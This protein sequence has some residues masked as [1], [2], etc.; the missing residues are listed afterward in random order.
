[1]VFILRLLVLTLAVFAAVIAVLNKF[2]VLIPSFLPLSKRVVIDDRI[3]YRVRYNLSAI[4][5]T[6]SYFNAFQRHS[7]LSEGTDRRHS[8]P[9]ITGDGFRM[10]A[11]G[12]YDNIFQN[13]SEMR[14]LSRKYLPI[15]FIKT[16][17]LHQFKV[18][19]LE[20]FNLESKIII[21]SHNSDFGV[22]ENAIPLISDPRIFHLFAQ[23][24][25]ISIHPKISCIPI[26]YENRYNTNGGKVGVILNKMSS[27]FAKP[28][29]FALGSFSIG[30][31][32]SEREPLLNLI[33]SLSHVTKVNGLS[34]D[35]FYDEMKTHQFMIAPRGN[36]IDTHRFYEALCVGVI[37]LYVT[38]HSAAAALVSEMGGIILSNWQELRNLSFTSF[39]VQDLEP[40]DFLKDPRFIFYFACKIGRIAQREEFCHLQGI[41]NILSSQY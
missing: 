32:P 11:D 23:N 21:I 16:D 6:Y 29:K 19:C 9:L 8:F 7:R 31:Y 17:F 40:L 15:I 3:V 38:K 22:D 27:G 10:L 5:D 2:V 39:I 28:S 26:G 36:G 14:S 18:Q 25:D 1:M 34:L 24:C 13:C 12:V 20:T 37:P 4:K 41:Q 30:T 33:N 35:E